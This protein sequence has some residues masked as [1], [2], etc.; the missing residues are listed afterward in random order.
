MNKD[1]KNSIKILLDETMDKIFID[2]PLMFSDK[3]PTKELK[4]FIVN[5]IENNW[6]V[7]D[8]KDEE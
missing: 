1:M 5:Y 7:Y 8:W 2:F 4:D 6:N 3:T